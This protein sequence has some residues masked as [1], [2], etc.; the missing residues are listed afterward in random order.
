M[1]YP[2]YG[3]N[4]GIAAGGGAGVDVPFPGTVNEN[5]ILIIVMMDADN[6]S[7]SIPTGDT[8]WYRVENQTSNSNLSYDVF[9]TRAEGTETGTITVSSALDAGQIVAGIMYR[10][11]GCKTLGDP[12][13]TSNSSSVARSDELIITDGSSVTSEDESLG[14]IFAII[15]DDLSIEMNAH[16]SYTPN[17]DSSYSVVANDASSFG[18]DCNFGLATAELATSGAKI[19]DGTS[20]TVRFL[21]SPYS[22]EYRAAVWLALEPAP[23]GEPDRNIDV[24]DSIFI[25]D[26]PTITVPNL[27]GINV[28]DPLVVTDVID[29]IEVTGGIPDVLD[30]D[31]FDP[32]I[33][34]DVP[35]LEIFIDVPFFVAESGGLFIANADDG[36]TNEWT[37]TVEINGGTFTAE[38]E[39]KKHGTH[40]FKCLFDGSS[41]TVSGAAVKTFTAQDEVYVRLYFY[42]DPD[43]EAANSSSLIILAVHNGGS[44]HTTL[45]VDFDGSG[46]PLEWAFYWRDNWDTSGINFSLGEWHELEIY[47]K[48]GTGVNSEHK[49]WIDGDLVLDENTGTCTDQLNA[50]RA[51][52]E[53]GDTVVDGT[54][55]YIDSVKISTSRIG[56]YAGS[57]I[58][59]SIV[60]TD[61][62]TDIEVV[63]GDVDPEPNVFDSAVVTDVPTLE[64]LVLVPTFIAESGG[65]FIANAETGDTFICE[66]MYILLL[67]M[68]G[69]RERPLFW[70]CNQVIGVQ[71]VKFQQIKMEWEN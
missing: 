47:T 52:A 26:E 63:G 50:I 20:D 23:S 46:S 39:A 12:F 61:V 45:Y 54:F 17:D 58:A 66:C 6:D 22:S 15:E 3:G 4:G 51:G 28:G 34:T 65:L 1:A 35:D 9:W 55:V 19:L 38:T 8:T 44:A 18:S 11:S 56:S 68:I 57:A 60:A 69:L 32:L 7:F 30:V 41:G 2:I 48:K 59:D 53:D 49:I 64:T 67:D 62:V 42:L 27:S 10:F 40:G 37:S 21:Y 14:V 70:R 13:T 29:D 5:D 25:T 36:T 24:G 43:L 33:I 16:P 31:V 71:D